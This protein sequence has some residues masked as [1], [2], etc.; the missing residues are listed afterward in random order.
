MRILILLFLLCLVNVSHAQVVSSKAPGFQT[1]GVVF[2][3]KSSQGLNFP[4]RGSKKALDIRWRQT[5]SEPVSVHFC[6]LEPVDNELLELIGLAD[7][8][9]GQLRYFY[10]FRPEEAEGKKRI[11]LDLTKVDPRCTSARVG[12]N[13]LSLTEFSRVDQLAERSEEGLIQLEF[14]EGMLS[15]AGG[16]SPFSAIYSCNGGGQGGESGQGSDSGQGSS[17][18]DDSTDGVRTG[19][20]SFI[21]SLCCPKP[22]ATGDKDKDGDPED[23]R[24]RVNTY[25][26][27]DGKPEFKQ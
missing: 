20:W 22:S 6:T 18:A 12:E 21:T 16:V 3:T 27:K 7:N 23:D 26:S 25:Y 1:T 2:G 11:A 24:N 9:E 13:S 8:R 14:Q 19:C 17:N 5:E 15:L 4:F 10:Y